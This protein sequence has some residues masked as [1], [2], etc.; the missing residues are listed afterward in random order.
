MEFLVV[1]VNNTKCKIVSMIPKILPSL[2][3]F[4]EEFLYCKNTKENSFETIAEELKM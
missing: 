1:K 3:T 4:H 2:T